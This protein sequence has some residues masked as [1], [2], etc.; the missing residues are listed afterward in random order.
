LA[1]NFTE[2]FG[3]SSTQR[4]EIDVEL[5]EAIKGRRSIRKYRPDPVRAGRRLRRIGR[6][7]ERMR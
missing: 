5:M 2:N 1:I 7:G 3:I 6:E 4:R